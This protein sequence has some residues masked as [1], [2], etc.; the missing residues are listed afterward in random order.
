MQ[1]T[2]LA[3]GLVVTLVWLMAGCTKAPTT[4]PSQPQ[5]SVS[6]I[7]SEL[8]EMSME[9][10]LMPFMGDFE[11]MKERRVVRVLVVHNR[12]F[13]FLDG[14]QERG[15][16]HDIFKQLETEL[17]ATIADKALAFNVA[18][19]PVS[20]DQ[21]IPALLEGRGD[22][23]A[24]NMTATKSREEL[25]DFTD[26]VMTDVSELVVTGPGAPAINSV[27]DLSGKEVQVR[28][29]SSYHE[30]LRG[31]NEKL[32]QQG[33]ALVKIV[34][35]DELLEDDDVLEMTNAGLIPITVVD[36]HKAEFWSQIFDKIVVHKDVAINSGGRIAWAVRKNSP[37]L[38]SALNS[39][40]G[41]HKQG[42][43][44]GNMMLKR[45]LVSADYVRNSTT[46]E[47]MQKFQAL[48]EMF[49]RYAGEYQFEWLMV[50]AQAYQESKLDQSAR[51][52]AGAVGVM[53]IKPET[54]ADPN[55]N[56]P[57]VERT[58]DNIHAG[59]KYLRFVVDQYFK[60][61]GITSENKM[62][63]AFASYNAGPARISRLRKQTAEMGLDPNK[64][65]YNVEVAAAR[66]IGRETVQ[67]VSNIYKYYIAYKQL[68]DLKRKKEK[69]AA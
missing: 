38:M 17:N 40:I 28:P 10:L 36:R 68:S 15:L 8:R 1:M 35:A 42:T 21:L 31:L 26:P 66:D 11:A 34:P 54:A 44:F 49:K 69:K 63:F 57:R 3:V 30:S 62:L 7:N 25:V 5:T 48:A 43:M 14:G 64:W 33:K 47:E 55:V 18:F 13:Y 23:V 41:S 65:F 50:A 59:V 58:D 16:T 27:E 2:R 67:Y 46:A 9:R 61:P 37:Q 19:I 12:M 29:S 51:S 52:A 53:Q 24:S 32:K 60:D 45:Y 4:S 20:R 6:P 56:V 22:V 39:F